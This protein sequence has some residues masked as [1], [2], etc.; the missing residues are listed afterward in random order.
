MNSK[1]EWNIEYLKELKEKFLDQGYPRTLIMQEFKRA[2]EVDRKDLLFNTNKKK[3]RTVIAPLVIT[4]SPANPKFRDWI[5]EE[6][7]IL[8]E[9]PKLKKLIPKIDVVT[10]Q[11][12]NIAKKTIRSRH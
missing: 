3:K 2:L 6:L 7:P 10:R 11:A 9:E 8:H 1:D 5:A 4:F 12:P